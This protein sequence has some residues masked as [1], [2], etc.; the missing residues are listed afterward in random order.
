MG[1]V[2]RGWR[3]EQ[4]EMLRPVELP[5]NNQV[6]EAVDVRETKLK[7]GQ[8]RDH[9]FCCVTGTK[10]FWY[11]VALFIGTAYKSDRPRRKHMRIS[12]RCECSLCANRWSAP[13]TYLT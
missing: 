12:L 3:A 5:E 10:F 11:I 13:S 8:N 7:I 9:T 4:F 2:V 6:R 1:A